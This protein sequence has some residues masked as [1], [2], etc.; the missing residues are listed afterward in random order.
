M[1]M[2]KKRKTVYWIATGIGLFLSAAS[3]ITYQRFATP[4]IVS[5]GW[6]SGSG[7]ISSISSSSNIP[8]FGS[9]ED[10][11][12]GTLISFKRIVSAEEL[13]QLLQTGNLNLKSI[14]YHDVGPGSG[15]VTFSHNVATQTAIVAAESHVRYRKL[16]QAYAVQQ[17]ATTVFVEGMGPMGVAIPVRVVGASGDFDTENAPRTT[18]EQLDAIPLQECVADDQISQPFRNDGPDSTMIEAACGFRPYAIVVHGDRTEIE[19]FTEEQDVVDQITF[20]P[21]LK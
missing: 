2:S 1:K 19:T 7:M 13:L 4:I 11:G 5:S 6:S 3:F 20:D 8:R 17:G 15:H 14:Y 18:L 16:A 12:P 9:P 21:P 10:A